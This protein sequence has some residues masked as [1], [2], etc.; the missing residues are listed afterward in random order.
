MFSSLG[1]LLAQAAESPGTELGMLG[2][3]LLLAVV[4]SV[5]GVAIFA[6]CLVVIEKITPFSLV[7]EIGEEHN[8]AVAIVIGAIVLGISIIIGASIL[9]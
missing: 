6:V 2:H 9:G 8:M 4:F 3:H 5:V 7:K 1:V